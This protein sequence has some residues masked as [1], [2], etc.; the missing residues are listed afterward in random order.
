MKGV[1]IFLADGFEDIEAIAPC[2]ILRRGGVKVKTVGMNEDPLV[3]SSH[4][5][6]IEA[7]MTFKQFLKS[8]DLTGGSREAVM[9]FPGGLPGARNLADNKALMELL[10]RHYENE[11][12]VAA[13]CAAPALVVAPALGEGYL[14]GVK[15]TCYDGFDT[16]LT[17]NGAEYVKQGVVVQDD[18]ITS[19]GPG[20]AIE[21]GLAV[22]AHIKGSETAD[23]VAAQMLI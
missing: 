2:D 10:R 19:R 23:T 4:K 6:T 22:L 16:G 11:G 14:T 21:F 8:A 7:D 18:I 3:T 20:F 9:I 5:V 17:A 1:Y 13:I 12:S 15:M